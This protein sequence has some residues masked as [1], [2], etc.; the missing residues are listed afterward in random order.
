MAKVNRSLTGTMGRSWLK[1]AQF[2]PL[3][4]L[5]PTIVLLVAFAFIPMIW[6][7]ALAFT[8]YPILLSPKFIG[9]DNFRRLKDDPV[10]WAS[11]RNTFSYIIGTV[12]PRIILG[13]VVALLLNQAIRGRNILRAMFYFPVVAP[14][15][16]VSLLWQWMFN[17][18]FG[19]INGILRMLGRAPV[20]W[21]TSSK[22]ALPAV[23]IMSVWKTVGWNMVIF[24]AGLQGISPSYYEAAEID[25]ANRWQCVRH[26]TLPLLRPI[27][28]LALVIS[29]INSSKVFEQVYIMTGGGPGY[30]TM[31]LVQQVYHSAFQ[32]YEMGYASAISL[33]LFAI[34]MILSVIQ[35]KYLGARTDE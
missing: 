21:L 32:S 27:I 33:V 14:L 2:T 15:V 23:M 9:L 4:F 30:S 17:T 28:L 20:P 24:L 10:F 31:T 22:Y 19:V 7:L 16:S 18:H 25:G 34:V 26:I 5:A 8:D 29:T 13:F 6:G 12:P 11:L 3:A 1:D 35:F